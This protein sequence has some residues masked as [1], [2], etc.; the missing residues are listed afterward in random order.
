MTSV[1]KVSHTRR[2]S[3]RLTDDVLFLF[4]RFFFSPPGT[5]ETVV[6]I[7]ISK[8]PFHFDL[9]FSAPFD[10]P[11][12]RLIGLISGILFRGGVLEKSK[13]SLRLAFFFFSCFSKIMFLF[14]VSFTLTARYFSFHWLQHCEPI[15]GIHALIFLLFLSFVVMGAAQV[16]LPDCD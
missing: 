1:T 16:L 11:S 9:G 13:F 15:R 7:S 10:F 5:A 12:Y 2:L 14:L 6:A 3:D 4:K 8:N